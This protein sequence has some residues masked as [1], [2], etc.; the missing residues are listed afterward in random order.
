MTRAAVG[1]LPATLSDV[2]VDGELHRELTWELGGWAIMLR[3]SGDVD[4]LFRMAR[5]THRQ[6][7]R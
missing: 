3:S 2:L 5:T 7:G 6:G 4:E 1:K